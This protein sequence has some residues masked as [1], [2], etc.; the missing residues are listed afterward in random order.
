MLLGLFLSHASSELQRSRRLVLGRIS[1]SLIV[2]TFTCLSTFASS[3]PTLFFHI[4]RARLFTLTSQIT[5]QRARPLPFVFSH[6]QT[7]DGTP[8][9]ELRPLQTGT[10]LS[11]NPTTLLSHEFQAVRAQGLIGD[12]GSAAQL[13]AM[14]QTSTLLTRSAEVHGCGQT[15]RN[16][17]GQ[18]QR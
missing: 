7:A 6:A 8:C 4:V 2:V 9:N 1:T 18:Y 5:Q 3:Q 15:R 14:R 11:S 12:H 17:S 10:S 13:T 16:G